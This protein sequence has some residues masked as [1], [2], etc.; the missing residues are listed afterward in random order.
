M[1]ELWQES[2]ELLGLDFAPATQQSQK[3]SDPC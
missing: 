2:A 3:L 1:V